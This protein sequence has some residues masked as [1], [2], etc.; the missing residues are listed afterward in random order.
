M[1]DEQIETRKIKEL[2]KSMM[3]KK[4]YKYDD[5]AK[6]LKVSVPTVKRLLNKEDLSV[7]RLLVIINWLGLD[8]AQ[9]SK[10]TKEHH[11][12]EYTEFTV[13]QE[14]FLA[15]HPGHV[16][17]FAE[18]MDGYT[19]QQL[20]ER[21]NLS[22]Q[23]LE[24]YLF[25]LDR[26]NLIELQKDNRVRLL[27][28]NY[29][30]SIEGGPLAKKFSKKMNDVISE[31]NRRGMTCREGDPLLRHHASLKLLLRPQSYQRLREDVNDLVHKYRTTSFM[32]C[33]IDTPENLLGV[34]FNFLVAQT[35]GRAK[36]YGIPRNIDTTAVEPLESTL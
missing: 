25:D 8:L 1:T 6:V 9:V 36:L 10:L 17:F 29:V 4:K 15:E 5:L 30:L 13:E 21:F 14:E 20:A 11:K 28:K 12:K 26:H 16:Y 27:N 35:D 7:H 2:I 3:K 32:E 24:K 34:V 23:S 19:P 33:M 18:L 22:K 31:L